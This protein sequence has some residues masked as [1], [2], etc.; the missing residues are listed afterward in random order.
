[1][2]STPQR[3]TTQVETS[4]TGEGLKMVPTFHL[5]RLLLPF[6]LLNHIGVQGSFLNR[7]LNA[8]NE[9]KASV[10]AALPEGMPY[11][12]LDRFRPSFTCPWMDRIG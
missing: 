9:H 5:R 12:Y 1:M 4:W 7:S 10:R 8:Y 6:L 11:L 3:S 2:A